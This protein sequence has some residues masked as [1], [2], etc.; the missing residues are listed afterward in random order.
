MFTENTTES[1]N[2]IPSNNSKYNPI[3]ISLKTLTFLLSFIAYTSQ[4]ASANNITPND[5]YQVTDSILKKLSRIHDYNLSSPPTSNFN[6]SGRRPGH[7]LQKSL[8]IHTRLQLLRRINGLSEA[9]MPDVPQGVVN[10]SFVIKMI[11]NIDDSVSELLHHYKVPAA[12]LENKIFTHKT[13]SDVYMQLLKIETSMVALGL[14]SIV[15]NDVYRKALRLIEISERI[16]NKPINKFNLSS[17]KKTPN[18]VFLEVSRSYRIISKKC[19][20]KQWHCAH[21]RLIPLERKKQRVTPSLVLEHILNLYAELRDI[22]AI[23]GIS[24]KISIPEEQSGKTP[25]DVFSIIHAMNQSLI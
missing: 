9:S 15:P 17:N 2:R 1:P 20:S 4:P 19:S 7:V 23:N 22:A 25:D 16:N 21:I 10:P 6:L 18:E 11:S 8:Q 14:P 5:V 24:T 3:N 13:P 12:Q